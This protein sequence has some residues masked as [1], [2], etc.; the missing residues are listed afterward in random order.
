MLARVDEEREDYLAQ[1]NEQDYV[2]HLVELYSLV[3]P[4]LDFDKMVVDHE[5]RQIPAERFPRTYHVFA[6]KSYPKPVVIY[7]IPFDGDESLLKVQPS[8][9]LSWQPSVY[10]KNGYVCFDIVAFDPNDSEVIRRDAEN[11]LGALRQLSGFVVS[12]VSQFNSALK[13][14]ARE[15]VRSRK[16]RFMQKNNLLASLGV[17]IRKRSDVSETFAIPARRE[18]RKIVF[19]K[20]EVRD[21]NFKPEPALDATNYREILKVIYDT[22]K[23]W[24]RLPST[25]RDKGEEDL[26]DHL[27]MMLSP[28]FS[29]EGTVTGE[30]FNKD[31][32]TDIL[33]RWQSHNVFVA[34]CK[35]WGGEKRYLETIDQLL[36]YL[37]WRDSK[38]AVIL[39]D[40]NKD[41]SASL[42]AIESATPSHSNYLGSIGKNEE[43]WFDY[44]FHIRGDRNRE[45]RI[46][47]L[48]FHFP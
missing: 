29:L 44:R 2:A 20:P 43:G 15:A 5:E 11:T 42:K 16:Q 3:V 27:I 26:R 33:V 41:I 36:G 22:G 28:H 25:Y 17:P 4:C 12:D 40:R 9:W 48:V 30:T 32:K 31:G 1:V 46:A 24:E 45:V 13:H 8:S 38:A 18:P 23:T 6:G 39:F 19:P 34:E 10:T 21:S 7:Q 14:E 37:T 47:V 35:F